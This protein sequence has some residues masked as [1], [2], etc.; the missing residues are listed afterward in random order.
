MFDLQ[1]VAAL[2]HIHEK[3]LGHPKLKP[4]ADAAQKQLE[5]VAEDTAKK[6]AAEKAEAAK[7]AEAL[8]VAQAEIDVTPVEDHFPE[9]EPGAAAQR[10][11]R[12]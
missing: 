9:S 11:R 3:A 12:L 2:L 10:G 6:L 4:L 5:A 7:Q 1:E 8:A